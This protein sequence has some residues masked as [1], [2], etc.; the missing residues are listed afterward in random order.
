MLVSVIRCLHCKLRSEETREV[1]RGFPDEVEFAREG[2]GSRAVVV[3][4]PSR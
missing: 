2:I 3:P 4:V 1:D